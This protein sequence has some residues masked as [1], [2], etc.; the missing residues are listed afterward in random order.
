M[1]SMTAL[2]MVRAMDRLD[3]QREDFTREIAT[4]GIC[5]PHLVFSSRWVCHNV[6]A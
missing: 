4:T 5:A 3:F 1:T 6:A 2:T